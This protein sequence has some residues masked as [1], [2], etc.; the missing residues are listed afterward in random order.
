M[1]LSTRGRYGMRAMMDLAMNFGNGA[2]LLR[3]VARRQG[4]S[5][6]YLEQLVTPLRAAGL[7]RGVRG[8]RGGYMLAKDP[9]TITLSEILQALEGS[10][11]PVSCIEEN[12]PC[13]DMKS[14]AT[15]ELWNELHSAITHILEN[16]SLKDL[17]ERQ[18]ELMKT[19]ENALIYHI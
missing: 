16:R 3:D 15:Q 2:I 7:L 4:I 14:C 8:A 13:V 18:M 9:E 12:H 10:L 1:K 17:A 6:K 11:A 5:L 19:Q